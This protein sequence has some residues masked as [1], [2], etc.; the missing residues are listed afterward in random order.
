MVLQASRFTKLAARWL[1]LLLLLGGDIERNPGPRK[2]SNKCQPRGP[3]DLSV[4]VT[5]ATSS[6]MQTCIQ[7][8]ATWLCDEL[9]LQL[10]QISWDCAAAPLALRAYGMHLYSSGAARY[11][12]VYTLT[13]MQD[14]YPHLRPHLSSAWQV[15]R[16]WQQHEPGTCRP[17]ISAPLMRAICSMALLWNWSRWLG[18]TLIGFLG[19]LHPAEFIS[20]TRSD[21]LLP[22]DSLIK[23]EVFYVFIRCPKTSRFARRQHC[24]IDDPLVLKFVTAVFGK[25]RASA[26]LFSGGATAYRRRWNAIL[27]RLEVPF[28]QQHDGCTPAVLRGSGATHMFLSTEDLPRVQWRGRWAQQKTL[29]FYVQEVAAQTMLSR[30]SPSAFERVKLLDRFASALLNDFILLTSQS[31]KEAECGANFVF[32]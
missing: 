13:G 31:S 3:L 16:K 26:A 7:D 9:G 11:R 28:L 19:M 6:R 14:C 30:L 25:L 23:D 5:P 24:K 32:S 18:I 21:I 4:G 8:F 29:E 20:L 27:S 1:R 22:A 15:D 10:D 2:P 12:F 17:V